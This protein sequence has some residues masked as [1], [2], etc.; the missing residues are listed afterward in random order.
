MK[1]P[2]SGLS[3]LMPQLLVLVDSSFSGDSSNDF[4]HSSGLLSHN[5]G[6]LSSN[7]VPKSEMELGAVIF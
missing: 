2:I 4:S 6:Y 3:S 7:S 1:D 5:S